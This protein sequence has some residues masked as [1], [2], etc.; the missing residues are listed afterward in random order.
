MRKLICAVGFLSVFALGSGT[1]AAATFDSSTGVGFVGKG[2]IQ[3]LYGWNNQTLQAQA[4]S[5]AFR[6]EAE[7]VLST[8]WECTNPNTGNETV[9]TT[10]VTTTIRNGVSNVTRVRNQVTGFILTGWRPPYVNNTVTAPNIAPG[11]CPG[12]ST[13]TGGPTPTENSSS[14]GLFASDGTGWQLLLALPYAP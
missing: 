2:D 12:T 7:A 5:V 13:L 10:T 14:A 8:E 4:D 1:A 11:T 3:S 6:Y 9:K